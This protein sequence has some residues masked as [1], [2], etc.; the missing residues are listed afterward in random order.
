MY[1]LLIDALAI[2]LDGRRRTAE[3]MLALGF[4][5]EVAPA[6]ALGHALGVARRIALGTFGGPLRSPL[7]AEARSSAGSSHP[8]TAARASTASWPGAPCRCPGGATTAP[9][10]PGGACSG[11]STA[12][13]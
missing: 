11:C 6:D 9:E 8:R 4:V 1:P 2:L 7:A 13:T 5:D 10:T 12:T 3:R